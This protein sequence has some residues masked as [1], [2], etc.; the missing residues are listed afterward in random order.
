MSSYKS[1]L[2]TGASGFVGRHFLQ[3]VQAEFPDLALYVGGRSAVPSG[4][5]GQAKPVV[6]DLSREIGF[7]GEPEVVFHVA[8]EKR[9]EGQMW[10]VN[11]E[12]T[13][14]LLQW[15]A[16]H[17]VKRFVYLSSVGVYGAR[18]NSG[19]VEA[20]AP[21]HPINTYESS[22][23][24]AEDLVREKCGEYG[25]EYVI[26]Q[27]SNVI[28]WVGGEAYPLLG[29]MKMI[30]R[31]WFTY[32]GG[33]DTCFNYVAVEDVASALVAATAPEAANRAFIINSPVSMR[34]FV[35][36][37]AEELGVAAPSR[38]LP[39]MVGRVAAFL[40]DGMR[41][42]TGKSIPFGRER[43]AELTNTTRYDGSPASKVLGKVYPL[44]IESAVR[45]L[46]RRYR[47]EG[48]L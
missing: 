15:S 37:I 7:E 5:S 29:L 11:L 42:V 43:F 4:L 30:K 18:K 38:R 47:R 28:G 46:V 40:A 26:L 20:G 2:V 45:Q 23:S 13:R 35:G 10:E 36:W 34:H 22:K 24:A 32:F 17:G 12:G 21:R 16:A 9:D 1:A 27:P 8:G 44:G 41:G 25:M 39:A 14:R 3:R 19:V 33:K 31:G 6:L 48:L